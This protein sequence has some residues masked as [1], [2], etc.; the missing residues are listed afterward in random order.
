MSWLLGDEDGSIRGEARPRDLRGRLSAFA[1][2]IL[3][4]FGGLTARLWILQVVD[5]EEYARRA[6]ENHLK[7]REIPAPRG[8][9]YDAHGNRIAEVRASYDLVVA[10]QD[11]DLT[12]ADGPVRLAEALGGPAVESLAARTDIATLAQRLEPL[13][14]HRPAE[15]LVEAFEESRRHSRFRHALLAGDLSDQELQ[16]VLAARPWLPGVQVLV[17]HRRSYSNGP[18]FAHLIGYM[19]EV[20]ADDVARLREKYQDT[21]Q[22]ADW[23]GPGDLMGKA[24]LEAAFEEHLRGQPGAYWAQVD[25][26]GRELG[27][28]AQ[29][30]LP[31]EEYFESIAHFLERGV[32]PE[33]RGNDL[34]LTVRRDLQ[35]KAVDLMG[36]RVGSV[37]MLEVQT[38]R[39]LA[40]ANTPAFDPSIFSKPLTEKDWFAVRDDP[41]KPLVDKA[42]QGI[43]PPGS[44]WKM[45]VAAALLGENVWTPDTSVTCPGYLKIGRRR[46]HCWN[47]HGHGRVTLETALQKS[48]DVYFYKAGLALGIDAVARYADMLGMGRPTG[49]GI[50]NEKGALNPS[51]DWKKRRFAGQPSRQNWSQGDTANAVIGQ[52]NTLATPMQLAR[53]V[54]ALA[55]GG[56]VMQPLLVDR[57]VGP[58]G[59][60]VQR[61]EPS[62]VGYLD[63]AP[64]S[65]KAIQRG[66]FAVVD[67]PG[68]TAHRQRLKELAFAGKTGTAQVVSLHRAK[69]GLDEHKDHAW[70]VAY[71]PYENPEVA[72]T[73]LVEHGEHGSST[74]APIARQMFETYFA[75]RMQ[76][77]KANHTRIGAPGGAP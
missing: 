75:D 8:S 68:G 56:T 13:L 11:V 18:L 72:I 62:V 55:N 9:I 40:I 64:E 23:Y 21:P 43:Y 69:A 27:R 49:V 74:A 17:R 53:M 41:G 12:P 46:F 15:E 76:E 52:G 28:S 32:E 63:L 66:M 20:R 47:R 30:G 60:V 4:F 70:F 3:V 1:A 38:G 77:A 2:V 37:V 25:A 35:Q 57:I 61:G 6:Q 26:L 58:D 51:S 22:G 42:L 50:N 29:V 31:G 39:V 71:A 5:G 65:L 36:D 24:G 16:R 34:H 19:R 10:P 44:T 59:E 73:V 14:E 33:M 45:V 7:R 48:C 54:A 67:K